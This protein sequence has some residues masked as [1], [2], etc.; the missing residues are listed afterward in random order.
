MYK[1]N[2]C[3]IADS[4]V[5]TSYDSTLVLF[6]SPIVWSDSAQLNAREIKISL[7]GK[8]LKFFELLCNAFLITQEDSLKFNQIKGKEIKGLFVKDTISRVE[9]RGNAQVAYFIKNEKKKLM[10]F[11]KTNSAKVNVY[12]E[13]GDVDRITFIDK[14]TSQLIPMKTVDPVKERFKGF[15]WN[16]LKKP[17]S[18][19]ELL[20]F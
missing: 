3:G 12:F 8:G 1:S 16:P 19:Y 20:K 17:K 7:T 15:Q 14:P 4:M 18:K 10:A 6:N 9:V 11:S 2:F 13:K 5:Y